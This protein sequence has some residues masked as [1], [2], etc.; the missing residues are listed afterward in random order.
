MMEYFLLL[1][2]IAVAVAVNSDDALNFGLQNLTPINKDYNLE[3]TTNVNV[4]KESKSLFFAFVN[5]KP[6]PIGHHLHHLLHAIKHP[7]KPTFNS[8][9]GK[10]HCPG[11]PQP[12]GPS[13]TIT[14]PTPPT[15][16]SPTIDVD[17]CTCISQAL[18]LPLN[19][20]NQGEGI[21]NPR[22]LCQPGLV[23]CLVVPAIP[24]Q[25]ARLQWGTEGRSKNKENEGRNWGTR[26]GKYKDEAPLGK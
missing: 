13:P 26:Q 10:P 20:V 21:I 8:P 4:T 19:T 25:I 15:T 7:H 6:N 12:T 9:C 11:S 17:N 3:N 16:P 1:K 2:M 24:I 5:P 14:T 23:C 18:C 22:N